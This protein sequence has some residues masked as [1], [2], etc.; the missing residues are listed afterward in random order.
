MM[1]TIT[2]VVISGFQARAAGGGEGERRVAKPSAFAVWEVEGKAGHCVRGGPERRPGWRS[3]GVACRGAWRVG[4]ERLVGDPDS[5]LGCGEVGRGPAA[6]AACSGAAAARSVLC[7]FV[8][9]RLPHTRQEGRATATRRRRLVRPPSLYRVPRAASSLGPCSCPSAAVA[10]Q[11]GKR[12]EPAQKAAGQTPTSGR[13][14]RRQRRARLRS[15][16]V[17]RLSQPLQ[18]L[19]PEPAAWEAPGGPFYSPTFVLLWG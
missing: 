14:K 10:A 18:P 4:G 2:I 9:R 1:I 13:N 12:E 19:S 3:R 5:R 7:L 11:E 17:T 6:V 16:P 15:F 8:G